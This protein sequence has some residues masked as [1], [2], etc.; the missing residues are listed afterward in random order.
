MIARGLLFTGPL[1]EWTTETSEGHTRCRAQCA[2]VHRAFAQLREL[3]EQRQS[4]GQRGG[5]PGGPLDGELIRIITMMIIIILIIILILMILIIIIQ[6][7]ISRL[8][9]YW[10]ENQ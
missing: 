7:K 8:E 3:Y 4:Q 2:E 10:T 6:K 9:D 5:R 1:P